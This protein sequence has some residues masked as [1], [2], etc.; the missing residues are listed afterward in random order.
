SQPR[1]RRVKMETKRDKFVR[2]ANKRVNNTITK[3][4]LVGGLSNRS[5]YEYTEADVKKIFSALDNAL[6]QAKKKFQPKKGQDEF[7][8]A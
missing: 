6:D 7:R 8:L 2:I 3:I 1:I 4:N 5:N